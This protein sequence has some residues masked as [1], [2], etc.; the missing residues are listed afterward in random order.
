[1]YQ[2][3]FGVNTRSVLVHVLAIDAITLATQLH[4]ALGGGA[5]WQ[6]LHCHCLRY[7]YAGICGAY[8][9]K[10][11]RQ[12]HR[13]RDGLKENR[14]PQLGM[15]DSSCRDEDRDWIDYNYL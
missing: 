12:N 9:R 4:L 3:K 8:E 11:H 1:M 2:S 14:R 15:C 10:D 6:W 7:T 5:E 13:D